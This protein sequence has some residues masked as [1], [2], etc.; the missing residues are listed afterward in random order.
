VFAAAAKTLST[1]E[2]F[3]AASLP[4]MAE[5]QVFMFSIHFQSNERDDPL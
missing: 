4:P 3:I 1:L 5:R 2:H